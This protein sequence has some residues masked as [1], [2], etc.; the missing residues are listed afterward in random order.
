M[1]LGFYLSLLFSTVL[2]TIVSFWDFSY[3]SKIY[4][5]E[6]GWN[7]NSVLWLSESARGESASVEQKDLKAFQT[8]LMETQKLPFVKEE[9]IRNLKNSILKMQRSPSNDRTM[10][11]ISGDFHSIVKDTETSMSTILVAV[12]FFLT[13]LNLSV[14]GILIFRPQRHLLGFINS[15]SKDLNELNVGKIKRPRYSKYRET[16]NLVESFNTLNEK[17]FM[18]KRIL[19]LI[20]RTRTVDDL[21]EEL[22]RSLNFLVKFDGICFV[23]V[24]G[25]ALKVE[26]LVTDSKTTSVKLPVHIDIENSISKD[27]MD[28]GKPKIVNDFRSQKESY[29]EHGAIDTVLGEGMNSGI[30]FPIHTDELC[31]GLMILFSREKNHFS[32]EDVKKLEILEEFLSM[33]YQKTSVVHDLVMSSTTG[34]TKLVEEKNNET[35]GH[36]Q[37]MAAYSKR[38]AEELSKNPK[39]SERITPRYIKEI[40]EQAL[41]HDIG[42]VGIPDRIL[43]KPGSLTQEEFEVLKKHTTIGYEILQKVDES[44]IFHGKKFFETGSKIVRHHHERWDGTGYPDGLKGEE[45]PLCARIVA[46]ADVFDALTSKRPYKKAFDPE[47]AVEMIVNGSGTQFDPDIVTAFSEVQNDIKEM[48]EPFKMK[49][50]IEPTMK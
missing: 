31:T 29:P 27:T 41:L 14:L 37:R 12:I 10:V 24:R 35:G 25:N 39:Y 48:H 6:N 43:L 46:V 36:I 9:K 32:S 22:H 47:R 13:G 18:Y 34:F 16:S 50:E 49:E 40:H 11:K 15:V 20:E 2:I 8:L 19:A 38:I 4:S 23:S 33:A 3:I 1:F 17:F 30:I 42:K 5:L 7:E 26:T 45:I 21:A 44:S 28:S